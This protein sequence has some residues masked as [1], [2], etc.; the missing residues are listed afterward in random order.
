MTY[1]FEELDLQRV[2]LRTDVRNER[3][4]AAIKKL[5]ATFEGSLRSHRIGA[6]GVTSDTIYFSIIKKEWR[7]VK[8][9]LEARLER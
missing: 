6:D 8:A 9:K 2:A 4:A 3:S 1:A 5:G 7:E